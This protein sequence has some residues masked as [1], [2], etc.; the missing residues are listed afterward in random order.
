MA[1]FPALEPDERSFDLGDFPMSKAAGFGGGEVRFNHAA[2]AVGHELG[3]TYLDRNDAALESIRDHYRGQ[4]GGHVSF[5]L[6]AII[7]QGHGVS[8][9]LVPTTGRW[10]YVGPPDETHKRGGIH[11][12]AVQLRFVGDRLTA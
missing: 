4:D 5:T 8:F 11:D 12:V 9:D 2:T 1:V 6:P 7:W 3:L 10:V